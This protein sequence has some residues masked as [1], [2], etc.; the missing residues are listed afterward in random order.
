MAVRG[1]MRQAANQYMAGLPKAF[2]LIPA[3]NA[4]RGF[5]VAFPAGGVAIHAHRRKGAAGTYMVTA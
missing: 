3:R 2:P 4:C 1:V 5:A